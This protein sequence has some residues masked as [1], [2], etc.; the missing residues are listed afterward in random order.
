[1]GIL[2]LAQ[3]GK[4]VISS[5]R[6]ITD[7]PVSRPPTGKFSAKYQVWT[8]DAWSAVQADAS[9]FGTLD[10]AD[11]YVRANYRRLSGG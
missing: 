7:T 5:D 9:T 3:N 8:G 2:T 11:E 10:E 1:M 4:F 6:G